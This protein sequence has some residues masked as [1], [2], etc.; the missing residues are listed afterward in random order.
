ME[1]SSFS[2]PALL[3]MYLFLMLFPGKIHEWTKKIPH[4]NLWFWLLLS[5]LWQGVGVFPLYDRIW[6]VV[7]FG[8]PLLSGL[9]ADNLAIL[10]WIW[11]FWLWFFAEFRFFFS[12]SVEHFS[13]V[14]CAA[15]TMLWLLAV[16]RT[17]WQKLLRF[18]EKEALR[19]AFLLLVPFSLFALPFGFLTGFL[20]WAPRLPTLP[21]TLWI[22]LLVAFPEE[23]LYRG[24]L[25]SQLKKIMDWKKSL[26]LTSVL[27][28]I[29]HFNDRPYWGFSYFILASVAG[30]V[31][32]YLFHRTENLHACALN[33]WAVDFLWMALFGRL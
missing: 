1:F 20:R 8:F 30:F 32:G 11:G 22:Y 33:H 2:R 26:L 18:P 5:L 23:A 3:M 25:F 29:S 10:L 31:Y 27:F 12:S 4:P 21:Q 14:A 19:L 7:Y 9:F 24:I 15:M 17:E 6:A 16:Q 13:A 28:G